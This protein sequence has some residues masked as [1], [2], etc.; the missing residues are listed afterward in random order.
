M[1]TVTPRRLTTTDAAT[2]LFNGWNAGAARHFHV[3][4][5]GGSAHVPVTRGDRRTGVGVG[6]E[7]PTNVGPEDGDEIG[8]GEQA[9]QNEGTGIHHRPVLAVEAV[10]SGILVTGEES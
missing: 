4:S 2:A 10:E 5:H 9:V 8:D 6:T 7:G 3:F 1:A